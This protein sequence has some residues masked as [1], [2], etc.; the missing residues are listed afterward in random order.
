MPTMLNLDD[1]DQKINLTIKGKSLEI[2]YPLE[3]MIQQVQ[4]E[5]EIGF[6]SLATREKGLGAY[7]E[8]ISKYILLPVDPEMTTDWVLK[9]LNF[10]QLVAI[11]EELSKQLAVGMGKM[12]GLS[13]DELDAKMR[14][15]QEQNPFPS[16]EKVENQEVT[17]EG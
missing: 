3:A 13:P 7:A 4:L 9:N 16:Q 12:M 10:F 8:F 15:I 17:P 2:D 1:L 14:E 5:K 11:L 6:L